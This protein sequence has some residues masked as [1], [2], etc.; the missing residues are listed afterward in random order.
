MK[1]SPQNEEQQDISKD[2]MKSKD[3]CKIFVY[4]QR[5]KYRQAKKTGHKDLN[6]VL[7][8]NLLFNPAQA[9]TLFITI[10]CIKGY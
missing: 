7:S 10:G 3:V 8:Q 9:V 6:N 4:E 2:A 1:R 5:Q